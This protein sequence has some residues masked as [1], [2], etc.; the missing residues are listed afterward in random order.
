MSSMSDKLNVKQAWFK[1]GI[2]ITGVTVLAGCTT[3]LRKSEAL[4]P[5]Y[6][7]RTDMYPQNISRAEY[8]EQMAVGYADDD[9][10]EKAIEYFRLSL[11]HNPNRVTPYI[12]LSDEYRK[13]E[14]NHLAVVELDNALK[15]DP[16]NMDVLKKLGDLYLDTKIYSKAREIYSQ[17]LQRDYKFE[18]AKW[19]LF[20][21]YKIEQKYTDA[22]NSL[23][24]VKVTADNAYKVAYERALI[25]KL[26]NDQD[27]YEKYLNQAYSLNPRDRDTVLEF[28]QNAF[29]KK[30]FKDSTNALMSFVDTHEFDFEISQNL[31]YSAVQSGNY[32]VAIREYNKQRPLT[33]DVA[34]VD[35]K[36]AHVYF[37]MN[38]LKQ[39]E[40]L[41]LS[42]LSRDENDEARYYLA[43]IF[44]AENKNEDAAFVLSKMP[45]NSDY[46]GEAQ[47]RLALYKKYE[48][49]ND[50]AIN[51]I[52][53]AFIKRPDQLI[54]YKTYA[55]FLIESKRYVEGVALLEQGIRLYP[56]DEDLRLKMA[57]LHYRLNNQKAFKKQIFAA[58]KINPESAQ[59]YSMLAELW[60]LKK[61]S[62][63]D[64]IYFVKK[65]VELK[66]T[67]KNIKPLL[68]WAL[69]Q[70]NNSTEAVA[71]FEEF[72]E[73]NPNEAFFARSLA[74][75]YSQGDIRLKAKELTARAE[76]IE[77]DDS[78]RSRFIFRPQTQ[79]VDAEKFMQNPTRLPASLEN[80]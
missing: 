21:I 47:V 5:V 77:N 1:I 62:P 61:K 57:F 17:L 48:G 71:I 27:N 20:Y 74:Q 59:V 39:A 30:Q 44:I 78:L 31:S 3:A 38:D 22:L 10:H 35:L 76:K 45:V 23:G 29:A 49:D 42:V 18:E 69:M 52:R 56:R 73:E 79:Q 40:K 13:T 55:D 32:D 15:I 14:R 19:A 50:E 37:L 28:V 72:Y 33:Y 75:V 12:G 63:D 8:Y 64:V 25:Y 43:Q 68:A 26:Q 11:L 65:A 58:L 16:Q 80:H 54:I 66:S 53:T 41:Y 34:M 36:K 9:Q 6:T 46:Y 24:Q 70:Q 60:Y 51:I 7:M 2:Y 67:D 4:P